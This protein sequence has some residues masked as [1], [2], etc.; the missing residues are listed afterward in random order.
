M[1][2]HGK[3]PEV[4]SQEVGGQTNIE[5]EQSCGSI[6]EAIQLFDVSRQRLL[7]VNE[8]HR[9]CG[10]L[11][12]NFHLTDSTGNEVNRLVQVN[13]HFKIDIP[14]PGSKAGK[15]YDWVKVEEVTELG[16]AKADT[17]SVLIR[18]RPTDNPTSKDNSV[19]HFFS[20]D[21]TSNFMVVR[22]GANVKAV[23]RGRNEVPNTKA[24]KVVDK[25][26]NAV[27]GTGA[28]AGF[29]SPQWSRLVHAVL[30]K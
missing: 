25:A 13:D 2:Q 10:A 17:Q 15:G 11:S 14:G 22:E 19:A 1:E 4:P 7:N 16:D 20:N 30:G 28:I 6:E 5:T 23:V 8:W 18:V 29:S 9:I 24:E 27:V 26:R 21:A 3:E 12:A